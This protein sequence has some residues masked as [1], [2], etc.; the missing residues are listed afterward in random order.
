M[1]SKIIGYGFKHLIDN[2]CI[3]MEID[4][5]S[6]ETPIQFLTDDELSDKLVK[7]VEKDMRVLFSM[8]K[9][10]YGTNL[11]SDIPESTSSQSTTTTRR[12]GNAF[13]NAFKDKSIEDEEVSLVDGVLE[14]AL[15]ALGDDALGALS[16]ET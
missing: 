11:S 7:K 13:L 16:D 6:E 1:K 2:G 10:K 12:R 8:Y 15:G 4:E 14:G 9:E 3:P 5:E